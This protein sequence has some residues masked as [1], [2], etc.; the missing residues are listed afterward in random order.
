MTMKFTLHPFDIADVVLVRS[1]RFVDSRGYFLES[2]SEG[3]F[4][5]LG[6]SARFVQ[7]NQSLSKS[8]G[9]LRGLH[10]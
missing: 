5:G 6:I 7:D 4:E 2:W 9:T 10:Y 8:R 1:K 3:K